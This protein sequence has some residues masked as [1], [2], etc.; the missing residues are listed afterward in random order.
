MVETVQNAT[1]FHERMG[2]MHDEG[3]FKED[4]NGNLIVVDNIEERAY[5]KE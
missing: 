1:S 4:E 2:A 5:L 3:L